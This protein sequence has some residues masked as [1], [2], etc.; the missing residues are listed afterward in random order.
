MRNHIGH[1]ALVN[2]RLNTEKYICILENALVP[3]IY[4]FELGHS[5]VTLMHDNAPLAR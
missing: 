5:D 4:E 2:E 1:I 3:T